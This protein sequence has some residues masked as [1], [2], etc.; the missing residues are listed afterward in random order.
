MES[1]NNNERIRY[2]IVGAGDI[3]QEAVLP[4]FQHAQ[5]SELVTLAN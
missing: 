2:A 5:N 4:A 3:A 1:T